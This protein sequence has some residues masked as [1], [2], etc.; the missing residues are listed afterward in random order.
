MTSSRMIEATKYADLIVR[1]LLLVKPSEQ[2]LIVADTQTDSEMIDSLAGSVHAVGGEFT[3]AIQPSRESPQPV[4]LT[5]PI[6]RAHEGADVIIGATRSVYVW[7]GIMKYIR[8]KR[9]RYLAMT[10][11]SLETMISGGATADYEEMAI[12]GREMSKILE[13]S[14]EIRITSK[15]W[16]DLTM[17]TSSR[18]VICSDGFCQNPGDFAAFPDGEVYLAPVP[19]SSEG[20]IMVD[21]PIAYVGV[22]EEP[23]KLTIRKGR[24]ENVEGKCKEVNELIEKIN[25]DKNARNCPVEFAIGI[26]PKCRRSGEFQEEKRKLGNIHLAFGHPLPGSVSEEEYQDPNV[27]SLIHS[28]LVLYDMTIDIDGVIIMENGQLKKIS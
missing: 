11:R 26:N 18:T 22:P 28:D 10:M 19:G 20:T 21:D 16:T 12:L 25:M 4:K 3:I 15:I 14:K 1:K 24:I 13:R 5:K 23:I 6:E 17:N 27:D 7:R 8:E 2:V 9:L